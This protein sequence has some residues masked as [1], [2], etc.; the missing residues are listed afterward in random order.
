MNEN[1]I[2]KLSLFASDQVLWL[3]F[4]GSNYPHPEQMPMDPKIFEA[5]KF[6]CNLILP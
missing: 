4:S 2:F 3:T 5:L 1:E 6:D